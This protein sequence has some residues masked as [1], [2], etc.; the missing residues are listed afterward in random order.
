MNILI[1]GDMYV[2]RCAF[3]VQK[4]RNEQIGVE[5]I[6][7]LYNILNNA[8]KELF[9]RFKSTSYYMYLSSNDYSNFRLKID[10]RYKLNRQNVSKPIYYV[11]AR[12]FL[13][14]NW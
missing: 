2:Y 14:E 13:V 5:P 6:E 8:I 3:A 7:N 9:L 4:K 12:E 11:Q 10:H 1:D